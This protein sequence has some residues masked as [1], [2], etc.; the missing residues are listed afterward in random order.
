MI[1][2][3]TSTLIIHPF[4]GRTRTQKLFC[5]DE[6]NDK[7]R[8]P[9]CSSWCQSGANESCTSSTEAIPGTKLKCFM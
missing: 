7:S 3:V 2:M 1:R 5:S 9:Y 6:G 8:I 4:D